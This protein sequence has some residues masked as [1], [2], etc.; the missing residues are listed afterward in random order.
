MPLPG[1]P[2]TRTPFLLIVGVPLILA[3]CAAEQAED[4]S[5]E[6]IGESSQA[7]AGG[8]RRVCSWNAR[9]L[10]N[11][12]DNLPKN[13]DAA[14]KVIRDNCDVVAL[15]EVMATAGGTANG[16]DE[17]LA[18]M[19]TRYWG[20]VI[21]DHAVPFP[22]TSNSER[23]AYIYRKSAAKLCD[24]WEG[25]QF[26]QDVEDVFIREPAYACFKLK[27]SAN[28]LVLGSYHALFGSIA[29]RKREIGFLDEDLDR[30]GKP[31]DL[32]AAMK[33]SRPGDPDLMLIGDFNL[34]PN[35][36]AEVL[37][38]YVDLTAGV[39]STINQSN[40]ITDNQ[41]DHAL[42]LQGSRLLEGT[43][44]ADTLDVRSV[45]SGNKFY[46]TVSDHLPIRVILK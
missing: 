25:V 24:G 5:L 6:P 22:Q 2:M 29:E 8:G 12:F 43:E 41:Y 31:D 23:Y 4:P 30:D 3:A 16:Y 28:E 15:Q 13:M 9:R 40:E 1:P 35:E 46:Q 18:K 11:N 45:V 42:V 14:V 38:R 19:G 20:G 33:A 34:K 21:T 39:G 26:M 36:L 27:A 7:V 32:F 44:P 37:P 17:L 10:G